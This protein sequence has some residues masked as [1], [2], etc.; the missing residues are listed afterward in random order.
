MYV[1]TE[2]IRCKKVVLGVLLGVSLTILFPFSSLAAGSV[3]LAWT[4]TADASVIGYNVYYGN[5]SR[6]YQNQIPVGTNSTTVL[7]DLADATQYYFAVTAVDAFGVESDFSAEATY[8]T[9]GNQTP[10]ISAI[11]G[12]TGTLNQATGP[13]S[14]TVNDAETAAANLVVSAV[15]SSTTLVPNANLVLGGTDQNR[16]VTITPANNQ[17]GTTL[18]TISVSDGTNT[19]TSSF[20]YSIQTVGVNTAPTIS[21]IADQTVTMNQATA[22]IAF[23]I[24]DAE[25]AAGS[26]TLSASSSA[27]ALVPNGNIVFGGSGASRTVKVTPAANQ[28]G[29]AQITVSVSD[30]TNSASS[31]FTV[32]VLAPAPNTPPTISTIAAQTVAENTATAAI[33]FTIGDAETAAASLTLSAS[34]SSTA[35]VPNGNIVFGGSGANRTVKVT[36]AANQ[37]GSTLITISVSDGTNSV[38]SGFN[39]TVQA[40]SNTP[41]TISAIANQNG[42]VSHAIGPISFTIGDAQSAAASLTL[43]AVSSDQSIVPNASIVFGSSGANRT[44]SITP[45]PGQ[46]GATA[47]TI[48]VS[49]GAATAQSSFAVSFTQPTSLPTSDLAPTSTYNGLFYESDAVRVQSAGSFKVTVTSGGKYSGTM[50]MAG[51]RYAFSGQFGPF[52]QGTNVI[53]RKGVKPLILNFGLDTSAAFSGNVSDGVF[54][55]GM[56][57]GST[58]FNT[59]THPAPYLGGYTLAVP[60]QDFAATFSMGN[61]YGSLKVDGAGNVKLSGVLADGTKITQSSQVSDDGTWPVFVPLYKGK[62]LLIGWISFANRTGDDLHGAINWIKQP[63]LLSHYYPSGFALAGDALGSI[64]APPTALALSTQLSRLQSESGTSTVVTS[65]KASATTGIFKGSILDKTT[66]KVSTFQGALLQKPDAGYGFVLEAN[67]SLPILLTQ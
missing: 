37:S 5:A 62:G 28:T 40:P 38:S 20:T 56:H 1:G 21:S 39:L 19:A 50:Q 53:V 22:A 25:T 26:L 65:I 8:R 66:G 60:G 44:V 48:T 10:T 63:D 6:G 27:T 16:T 43:S 67:Q 51:G 12:Q 35:L 52:C 61:G 24:G 18:I 9:P 31:I 45:A 47:I 32:T 11:P 13:I 14:F 33:P 41:P 7:S 17:T 64:Y 29:S 34:S 36:P 2:V 59:I 58:T 4:P 3:N 30:G 46:I 54:A 49:D 42:Y 57:G 23:T 15:S 55:A